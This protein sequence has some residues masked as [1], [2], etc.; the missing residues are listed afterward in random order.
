MSE[1]NRLSASAYLVYSRLEL[2]DKL[3][4]SALVGGS[5]KVLDIAEN[6][7]HSLLTIGYCKK[8]IMHS[9]SIQGH[10]GITGVGALYSCCNETDHSLS[11]FR[12]MA[13]LK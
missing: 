4:D 9:G 8:I 11:V 2:H 3:I 7:S 12:V 13:T 6:S 10:L 1:F 5:E